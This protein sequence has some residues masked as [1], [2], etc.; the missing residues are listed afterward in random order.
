MF[1]L[2]S[3]RYNRCLRLLVNVV[4]AYR[5]KITGKKELVI[6]GSRKKWHRNENKTRINAMIDAKEMASK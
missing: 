4:R 3:D 5:L 6:V 2:K 1:T